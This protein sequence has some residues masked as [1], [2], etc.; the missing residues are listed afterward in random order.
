[1]QGTQLRERPGRSVTAY[2]LACRWLSRAARSEAEIRLRLTRMGFSARA[3]DD[4][5]RRLRD[6]R[7]VDDQQLARNRAQV[8]ARRGYGDAWITN[9]LL[10]RG[11]SEGVVD[12]ALAELP[13]ETTRA[14]A[15]LDQGGVRRG[16]RPAW[17]LLV[18]RGFSTDTA[19]EVA[20]APE[21]AE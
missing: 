10:Q 15:W 2:D 3:V 12:R 1:M 6:H 8:L 17:R 7:F 19:E 20:G 18:Q 4:S 16:S 13:Q 11:L 9:D 5:L 21:D 14:T